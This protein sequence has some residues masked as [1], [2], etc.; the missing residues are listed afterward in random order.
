MYFGFVSF[1]QLKTLEES[2]AALEKLRSD[3][4]SQHQENVTKLRALWSEEKDKELRQEV[5]T[6]LTKAKAIWREEVGV[7]LC[8]ICS[9]SCFMNGSVLPPHKVY[10]SYAQDTA[11]DS[12]V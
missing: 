9:S 7:V 5:Q 2:R 1:S 11:N 8:S 10:L 3:L 6:Q 4:E 12:T